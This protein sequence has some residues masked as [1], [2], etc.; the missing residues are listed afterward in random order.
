VLRLGGAASLT[1]GLLLAAG[2]WLNRSGL[3]AVLGGLAWLAD[4]PNVP[5]ESRR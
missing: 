5:L 1:V 3:I 4:L 2:M